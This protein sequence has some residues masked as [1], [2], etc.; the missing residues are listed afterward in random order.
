MSGELVSLRRKFNI[1]WKPDE[2][3]VA[4]AG[5]PNTGK[6]TIFNNLTGMHQH[7]GNWPGKTV[8]QAQGEYKYKGKKIKL[9][10][11]PGTY[12]LF[13]NSADETVARDFICFGF[14]DVTVVVIDA[15][16]LER[17]LNLVLQ[18]MEI[19]SQVIVCVNLMDEAIR[20][21]IDV[22]IEKL[23]EQLGVPVIA[24]AAR[25]G[26]GM[27]E[28]KE[29]INAMALGQTQVNPRLIKYDDDIELLVEQIQQKIILF[30]ASAAINSRWLALRIL[31]RDQTLF[32]GFQ[33]Y[34]GWEKV[35]A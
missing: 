31:D 8:V 3:L 16:C 30:P 24:T 4:I 28:L 26:R 5:N 32:T 9:V 10:D 20:K 29:Q 33:Y 6:S 35:M 23:A 18:I 17:N 7:T 21:S 12:S 15:T 2:I 1:E 13:P 19:T 34:F 25:N 27:K 22:D 11:L 14:P